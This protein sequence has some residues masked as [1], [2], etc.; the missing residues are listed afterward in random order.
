MPKRILSLL[1]KSC[2]QGVDLK[3]S[4]KH[5]LPKARFS[6]CFF[7]VKQANST[8]SNKYIHCALEKG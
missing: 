1:K 7:G 4:N 5:T 2:F 3:I 8:F 6:T